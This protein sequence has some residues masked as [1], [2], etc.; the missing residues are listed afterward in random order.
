MRTIIASMVALLFIAPLMSHAQGTR[1][2]LEDAAKALGA[3]GT[4]F[5]T[6]QGAMAGQQG[7]QFTLKSYAR[8][9]NDETVSLRTDFERTRAE[10]RGGGAPAPRQVQLVSGDHAW[11]VVGEVASS[12]PEAIADRQFQLWSTP[13]GIIK[14]A[15]KYNA[16]VEGGRLCSELM[17]GGEPR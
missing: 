13:H 1:A 8:S 17:S 5:D 11:N 14:A 7:P 16:T 10:I 9:I 4:M 3:S 12:R 15:M 2:V 6:G